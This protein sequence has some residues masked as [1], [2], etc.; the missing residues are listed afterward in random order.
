LLTDT[1]PALGSPVA[2]VSSAVIPVASLV[3]GTNICAI[4][5]PMDAIS[6]PYER[7]IGIRQVTGTAA[8]TAGAISVYLVHDVARVKHYAD[9]VN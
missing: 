9:A 8:F 6:A 3:A 4:A 2:L 1:D 7:Y 5:L